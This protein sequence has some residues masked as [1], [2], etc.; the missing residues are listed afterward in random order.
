MASFEDELN[1]HALA[2]N[3]KKT[4]VVC[5]KPLMGTI[6]WY[7]NHGNYCGSPHRE[8]RNKF[9]GDHARKELIKAGYL[10]D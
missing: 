6:E 3:V 9:S 2:R 8:F 10:K 4:C 7:I 1:R 5:G